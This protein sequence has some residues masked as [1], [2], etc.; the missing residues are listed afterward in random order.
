MIPTAFFDVDVKNGVSVWSVV[1]PLLLDFDL[2]IPTANTRHDGRSKSVKTRGKGLVSRAD[3]KERI[4]RSVGADGRSISQAA[5]GLGM[6]LTTV[7]RV[8]RT[9]GIGPYL[10]RKDGDIPSQSSQV[11]YGWERRG[12]GLR[13]HPDEWTR[14]LEMHR[15][16][17]QGLSF[18]KIAAHLTDTNVHSKNGRR[19]H[20]KSVSQILEFNALNFKRTKRTRR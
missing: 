16:R 13:R 2:P 9:L 17:K 20:A 7:R 4:R 8:C 6:S 18:H 11:P 12:A 10:R 3:I 19:W 5:G 14:V 15:L 1:E